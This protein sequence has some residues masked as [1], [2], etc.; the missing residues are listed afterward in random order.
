MIS[1]DNITFEYQKDLPILKG[2]GFSCE[3]GSLVSVVGPNGCGKTTFIKC[4][5]SI[6]KPKSG[7]V[8][9]NEENIIGLKREEIAKR[10]AYVP[11]MTGESV[12]ATVLEIVIMGQK[13]NLG[14]KLQEKD[15]DNA[16]S[17]LRELGLESI[18]NK[19]YNDLS[20]GQKQKVLIARAIAQDTEVYLFD[21]PT[22]FLDIKNQYEIIRLAKK[23]A[24]ENKIVIMV[25]HDLNMALTYSDRVLM[26]SK[27]RVIGFDKPEKV[28]TRQNIHDVYDID[29]DIIDEKY[30]V[31]CK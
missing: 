25:V 13:P 20:G 28:L 22:S 9:I 6:L 15:I 23:M 31:P 29:V 26:M 27:G 30:I 16:L 19:N 24:Q 14:W 2:V 10:I 1:V 18:A 12:N 17:V 7:N 4:I 5:N 3:N 11:Q 8:V 21:E